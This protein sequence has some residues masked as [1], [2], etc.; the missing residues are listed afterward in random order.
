MA[1]TYTVTVLDDRGCSKPFLIQG[2]LTLLQIQ[3]MLQRSIDVSCF[4]LFD[5]STFVDNVTGV[6][7][8]EQ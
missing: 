6:C 2:T 8:N 3:W 7:S 1:S 4:G 5:G